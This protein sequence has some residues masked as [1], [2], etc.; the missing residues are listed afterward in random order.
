MLDN[1]EVTREDEVQ[2]EK[3]DK[4]RRASYEAGL[5]PQLPRTQYWFLQAGNLRRPDPG[6]EV[7]DSRVF[8]SHPGPCMKTGCIHHR[9]KDNNFINMPGKTFNQA[10]PH[11]AGH[12]STKFAHRY[13]QE[14]CGIC[15][16][17]REESIH[18]KVSTSEDSSGHAYFLPTL[19]AIAATLLVCAN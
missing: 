13:L 2:D 7:D 5:G 10:I 3:L 18:R 14:A 6:Q 4:A 9:S 16:N 19:P 1:L 11:V 15:L 12:A 17:L 8:R